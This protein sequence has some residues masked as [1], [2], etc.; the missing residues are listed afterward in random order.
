MLQI[1][2]SPSIQVEE[3]TAAPDGRSSAE[4][5]AFYVGFIRRQFLVVLFVMLLTIV[6]AA[7]YLLTTPPLYT[8]HAKI[9]I[10]PGKVQLFQHSI[11]GDDPINAQM[12]DSQIEI[13]KSDNF[14][15]SI[16]KNLQLN[17]N[18]EFMESTPRVTAIV[19]GLL[20]NLFTLKDNRPKSELESTQSVARA[21]EKRLT[22]TRVGMTT[23]IDI[24]FKSINPDHAAQIANAIAEGYIADQLDAKY[25]AMRNATTWLEDRLNELRGQASAAER[26]VVDYKAKNNIVETGGHL[27]NQDQLAGLNSSLITTHA[28]VAEA[29]ARLDRISKILSDNL[30]PASTETATVA[31][32]L[33]NEIIIRLRQQYLE[34]ARREHEWSIRY[35]A[36]HLA[37]VNLRN[38]MQEIRHSIVDE[39][40]QI[41]ETYK[42]D[43]DIAKAR[44][45]SLQKSLDAT[46]AQS[47]TTS[48]AQIELGELESKARA[49][50][51]LYDNFQQRYTDT[52]Q[53]QSF[54]ITEARVI[55]RASPPLE[56][57]SPKSLLI[58]AVASMGGLMLGAGLGMLRE[59]SDR[60][61]RTSGQVEAQLKADCIAVV[62]VMKFDAKPA[63]VNGKT[64]A[65]PVAGRII[66]SEPGW[67]RY[68]IDAPLSRFA[69]SIR[70]VKVGI[71]LSGVAKSNKV[72]GITSSLPNEGKSTISA[73]LA[74]LAAHGGARVILVDCDL[75]KPALSQ[76]LAPHATLGLI[77]VISG[78][79]SLDQAIWSHPSSQL[80]FLPLVAKTR[81]IHTSEL[82]S[83]VAMRRLFDRLRET[84]D[85]VIVD[86]S[87]VAP[88][89]DVRSANNL[90]D[91]YVF[92]V[93]WG[94][95]K[96]DVV[97]HALN[98]ARGVYDNLL[99]V[100]L[101]KADFKQLGRYDGYHGDYY[102][103][104][105]YANY[106]Y[107]D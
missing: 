103:N 70:A 33:H 46:V 18:P 37:V 41:A 24:D 67:F 13:L 86:L 76:V 47:Q 25:Q 8:G 95:T 32:A 9:M 71:D 49:Y 65:H 54:P 3:S 29:Q 83:S 51:A 72:I 94:K 19:R 38:Q 58:L 44:E 102:Y 78:A 93:E 5:F 98:T 26:A 21:F 23:V 75:R 90:L 62:P 30:D 22:V 89:V 4:L 36:N 88:V 100:V 101:N 35:G 28:A 59:I 60:R 80:S 106:G 2:K 48:K 55:T 10:D 69:E 74:Q 7:V 64:A 40:K 42:S 85:Y 82:L 6:L 52:L 12:V 11:F 81:L 53:Q 66:A 99:G 14:A 87:P 56:K 39:S 107:T 92:V 31:D 17:Q 104:R 61:F 77:E 96:I 34:L 79:A 68:V 57:T 43:L 91:S 15:L 20:S 84:Y 50:R 97:Q 105:H 63:T 27:I 73:S 45:N 16:I 1:D